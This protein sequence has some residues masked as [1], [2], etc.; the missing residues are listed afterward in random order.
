MWRV[1]EENEK[2]T[3]S[4]RIRIGKRRKQKEKQ[5]KKKDDDGEEGGEEE[6]PLSTL[7]ISHLPLR[8]PP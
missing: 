6:S 1:E 2:V 7:H 5:K 3:H 8:P 4:L